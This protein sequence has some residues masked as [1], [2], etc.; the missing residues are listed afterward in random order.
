MTG[1]EPRSHPQSRRP[2]RT[3]LLLALGLLIGL[4]GM[5]AL[6]TAAALPPREGAGYVPVHHAATAEDAPRHQCPDGE[7]GAP[8]RHTGHADRMCA[9]AALPGSPGILAPDT[10]PLTGRPG[11]LAHLPAALPI[12]A[13]AY[14]PAGGRAPPLITELQTMRT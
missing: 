3:V 2:P 10:A 12:A 4:L 1:H 8:A 14:E 9:S 5:H 7:D 13:L 11:G 6:G